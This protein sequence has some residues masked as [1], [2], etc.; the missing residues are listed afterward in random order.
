MN[1]SPFLRPFTRALSL[2]TIAIVV[3]SCGGDSSGPSDTTGTQLSGSDTTTGTPTNSFD[4]TTPDTGISSNQAALEHQNELAKNEEGSQAPLTQGG[5]QFAATAGDGTGT[6]AGFHNNGG[7]VSDQ[8]TGANGNSA[9]SGST[10]ANNA[11]SNPAK[12]AGSG[13]GFGG[14]SAAGSGSGSGLGSLG[15]VQTSAAGMDPSQGPNGGSAYLA[16]D[17]LGSTDASAAYGSAGGNGGRMGGAGGAFNNGQYG[18]SDAG[19]G[20]G[21]HGNE[22]KNI[23]RDPASLAGKSDAEKNAA[24]AM[25]SK[26]PSNYFSLLNPGDNIFKI[27]ERRYVSKAKQW[28]IADVQRISEKIKGP[29]LK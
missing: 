21:A 22:V 19:V 24:G 2:F 3:F 12:A 11:S 27:V 7:T 20:G 4:T 16:T 28:A 10:L 13:G 5:E 15:D 18:D 9:S 23:G 17:V 6:G 1:R 14:G 25:G 29:T 8:S 26:D